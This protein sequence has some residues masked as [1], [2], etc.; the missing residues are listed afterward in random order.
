MCV[1]D[2]E[3]SAAGF[4]N[5]AADQRE[6]CNRKRYSACRIR[7]VCSRESQQTEI[8][9]TE[10]PQQA[11]GQAPGAKNAAYFPCLLQACFHVLHLLYL[12]LQKWSCLQQVQAFLQ[13]LFFLSAA[14]IEKSVAAPPASEKNDPATGKKKLQ[15]VRSPPSNTGEAQASVSTAPCAVRPYDAPDSFSVPHA[16]T[17][18]CTLELQ[19]IMCLV[20]RESALLTP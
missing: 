7:E 2:T 5:H 8:L 17:D 14:E 16:V 13:H 11:P 1:A 4:L 15:H 6:G 18:T 10:R 12:M 19:P 3:N 20:A 9:A